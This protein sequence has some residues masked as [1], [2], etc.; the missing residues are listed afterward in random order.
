M[1]FTERLKRLEERVERDYNHLERVIAP[2]REIV[3]KAFDQVNLA[4][5]EQQ[6]GLKAFADNTRES[7]RELI[8][9]MQTQQ[10]HHD[11]EIQAIKQRLDRLENPPAA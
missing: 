8:E 9:L 5:L 10:E 3:E 6:I 7:L 11:R 1:S 2:Q 4:L